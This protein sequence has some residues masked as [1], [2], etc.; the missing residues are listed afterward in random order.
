MGFE[1]IDYR[2]K[3]GKNSKQI[4]IYNFHKAAGVLVEYGFD[5]IRVSDDWEGADFLAH[6][7]GTG[8]TLMVQLKTCLVVDEKYN[9]FKDLYMCFPLDGTD[10]WYL[11]KHTRLM[12]IARQ[13][14]PQWFES[15]RWKGSHEYWSYTAT[16]EMRHALEEFEYKSLYPSLGFREAG[17]KTRSA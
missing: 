15:N 2:E 7:K 5:C 8:E 12:E 10:N 3:T 6:H 14:A 4:E 1:H 11:I 13:H 9:D 16:K 17:R